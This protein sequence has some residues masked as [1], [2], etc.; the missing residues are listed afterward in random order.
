MGKS[1]LPEKK[2][3]ITFNSGANTVIYLEKVSRFSRL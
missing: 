3:E 1:K 2:T